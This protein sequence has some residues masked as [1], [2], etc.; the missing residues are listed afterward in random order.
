MK[1]VTLIAAIV[2]TPALAHGDTPLHADAPGLLFLG[3]AVIAGAVIGALTKRGSG[4]GVVERQPV[5]SGRGMEA[6]ISNGR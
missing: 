6:R 5:P 3:L 4:S 1:F 2:A